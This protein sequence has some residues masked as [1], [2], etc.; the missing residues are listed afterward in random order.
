VVSIVDILPTI[1]DLFQVKRKMRSPIDGISLLDAVKKKTASDRVVTAYLAPRALRNG[2]PARISLIRGNYKYI[3]NQKMTEDDL[4]GFIF[5]PPDFTDELFDLSVDP[6]EKS[7][8]IE[9]RPQTAVAFMKLIR[10][11][12][13]KQG[14]K[15]FLQQLS[16]RLKSLGYF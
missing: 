11:L 16:E 6:Y 1:L 8:I 12:E 5:A 9:S 7:N 4:S 15:G 10:G 14:K 2:I 13:F 3:F